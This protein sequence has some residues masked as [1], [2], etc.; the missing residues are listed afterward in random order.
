MTLLPD[1]VEDE[2]RL[3]EALNRQAQQMLDTL[4]A[5]MKMRTAPGPAKRQRHLAKT[6][7]E[8]AL[9]RAVLAYRSS[10]ISPL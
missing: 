3:R 2:E 5:A 10:K 8:D 9:L 4:D 7:L 1:P 6:A